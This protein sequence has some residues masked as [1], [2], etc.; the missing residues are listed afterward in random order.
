MHFSISVVGKCI[1]SL[2]SLMAASAKCRL[3][4]LPSSNFPPGRSHCGFHMSESI[5][6]PAQSRISPR[7][8]PVCRNATLAARVIGGSMVGT[9]V[10][11]AGVGTGILLAVATM[12]STGSPSSLAYLF[13]HAATTASIS[14]IESLCSCL[15]GL[16]D[17]C[18]LLEKCIDGSHLGFGPRVVC[19]TVW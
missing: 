12:R 9:P 1:S 17:T 19:S 7:L 6:A 3:F 13:S 2:I 5:R 15:K 4:S 11:G 18:S 10:S 16:R 14:G 8:R